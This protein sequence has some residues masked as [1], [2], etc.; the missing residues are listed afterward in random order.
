M[1]TVGSWGRRR[2]MGVG[3]G[4]NMLFMNRSKRQMWRKQSDSPYGWVETLGHLHTSRRG[5]PWSQLAS[6]KQADQA[7]IL[8]R[9]ERRPDWTLAGHVGL[10]LIQSPPESL[11]KS[12]LV[13]GWRA[14]LCYTRRLLPEAGPKQS[15]TFCLQSNQR[16]SSRCARFKHLLWLE[17]GELNYT[18]L[19]P[20]GAW[21]ETFAAN[22]R[23]K[24]KS[25]L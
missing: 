14:L 4:I 24:H 17:A 3:G 6:R 8:G 15:R 20:A 19:R 11:H 2:R 16:S 10:C 13:V 18:R 25:Q 21:T 1:W 9:S 7:T 5:K 23:C 12:R 22:R